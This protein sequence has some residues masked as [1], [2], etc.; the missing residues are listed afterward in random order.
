MSIVI[1]QLAKLWEHKE[2]KKFRYLAAATAAVA[3]VAADLYLSLL[4]SHEFAAG[5]SFLT[6]SPR[7]TAARK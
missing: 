3:A 7:Q 6:M 4:L 1:S 5:N 2:K